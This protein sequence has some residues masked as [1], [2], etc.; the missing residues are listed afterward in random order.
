MARFAHAELKFIEATVASGRNFHGAAK[1]VSVLNGTRVP[2][3]LDDVQVVR[4]FVMET[5]GVNSCSFGTGVDF[6]L[7]LS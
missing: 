6:H 1:L 7:G 5:L 2:G 3:V 4:V